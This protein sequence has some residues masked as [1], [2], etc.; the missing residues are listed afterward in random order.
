MMRRAEDKNPIVNKQANEREKNVTNTPNTT[1]FPVENVYDL[2]VTCKQKENKL[3]MQLKLF[4][5]VIG[6][7]C[8]RVCAQ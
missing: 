8:E 1:T 3:K 5:I 6:Q 4:C 2:R 7:N